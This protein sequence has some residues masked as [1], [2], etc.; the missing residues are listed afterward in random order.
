MH[1]KEKKRDFQKNDVAI[2]FYLSFYKFLFVKRENL[3]LNME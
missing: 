1:E 3:P 2:H